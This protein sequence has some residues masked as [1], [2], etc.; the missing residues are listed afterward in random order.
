MA[1]PHVA[2]GG[3]AWSI[4]RTWR[5]RSEANFDGPGESIPAL[6]G[7][8]VSGNRLNALNA[9]IAADPDP[10]YR[11]ELTPSN[12]EVVAGDSTTLALDVGSIADWSGAVD[13][14]VSAEPQL[15]VS[16][17]SNQAQ[18]GETVDVQVTTT[19]ETAWGEYVIT[20]SGTDVETGEMTR[21]VS[22]TVYVLPQ[23]LWFLYE[24]AAN[25]DIPDDDS[26]GISRVI[27]VPETGVVF[28]A[29]VSVDITHSWRVDLIV[30][31]TSPEGTTQTLHDRAGSSEDDLV[32]TWDVD[33][34]NG[35]A[36]VIG[37]G[38]SDN[39]MQYLLQTIGH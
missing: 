21:D 30:T 32:A 35:M 1:S 26:N 5:Y 7:K 25:A 14:S 4:A 29:E 31:L 13:L 10:D 37:L 23:G 28:G 15:D 17:S 8:T 34:F 18:N 2:G 22:A 11:L 36:R 3:L 27:N 24:D 20:V 19:E 6:A 16:L 12:Q 39:A 9:L 38:M 33:S